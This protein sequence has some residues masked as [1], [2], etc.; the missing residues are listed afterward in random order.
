MRGPARRFLCAEGCSANQLAARQRP[1]LVGRDRGQQNVVRHSPA[2]GHEAESELVF[3]APA[4]HQ[5][6]AVHIHR[7]STLLEIVR[8]DAPRLATKRPVLENVHPPRDDSKIRRPNEHGQN[9]ATIPAGTSYE[10]A[11][12]Q[13]PNGTDDAVRKIA[14]RSSATAETMKKRSVP[15]GLSGAHSPA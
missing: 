5:E 2:A 6:S 8:A 10:Y 7:D 9:P 13:K 1:G 15:A 11:A 3:S 12:N 4:E 14:I